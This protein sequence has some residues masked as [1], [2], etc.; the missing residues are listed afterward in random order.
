[1]SREIKHENHYKDRLLKLIPTEIV[2]AY[3]VIDGLIPKDAMHGGVV[4]VV[5]SI[6]LLA[7]IPFYLRKAMKVH[8]PKQILFTMISFVVW[9][10]SLGGPFSF[11]GLYIGYIG[12]V[13]LILWTLLIPFFYKPAS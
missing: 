7:L 4:S 11:Y 6:I 9:V 5:S 8:Q 13:G 3:L 12:S 2:A 10:Y 1:M